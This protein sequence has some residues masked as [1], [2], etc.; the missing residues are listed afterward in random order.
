MALLVGRLAFRGLLLTA[1]IL[2]GQASKSTAAGESVGFGIVPH[3]D[4]TTHLDPGVAA[5][6]DATF[7]FFPSRASTAGRKVTPDMF[8]APEVCGGCHTEI[9]SQWK[10]SMH[11]NAWTDPVYRAALNAISKA[12]GG[13][14]DRF[15]M[16]C[17]TPVGVVTGEAT[18]SGDGM[19]AIAD[20]GVQCEV[21]HNISRSSGIGN[22][23]Y[24]LTPKLH[25]RPLKFG[26]FDDAA[27][28]YHDTAYSRLHTRSEFCGQCHDVTHPFNR[29]AIERTYS[30]WRDSV[31]AATGVQCQDCHMKPVR[32]RA[33]P[34]SKARERIYTHHF[35]G[36][37]TIVPKMLGSETHAKL[38][39]EMLRSAARVELFVAGRLTA[40]QAGTVRVR[41]T[42][43]GAGHKLPTGFPE[44]REM[45]IDFSV[46]DERGHV[47]YRSG[48]VKDGETEPGTQSFKVVLGDKD[49]KV[50]DLNV[51]DA[52]RILYDTR[53]EPKGS[54]DVDYVF[55][56]PA[57][58]SGR[59]Q[60]VADLNYWSFSQAFLDHLMGK[61]APRTRIIKMAGAAATVEIRRPR[62]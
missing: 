47:L 30:E 2:T 46:R 62:R 32:G 48:A 25:G 37:N 20:R 35:V 14:A 7:P 17:H 31:Y 10:G 57:T 12:S 40:G 58:L 49:G 53:L 6:D 42:N 33:T 3:P 8:D 28:P 22:G 19:S 1:I 56:L 34:F 11:S 38:A 4:N 29:T 36:G 60:L 61:D 23:A 26:P 24:V 18:P 27:S 9:Y 41:V 16:G 44:G 45:W 59:I 51:L 39:A 43:V 21:C 52:D 50:V 13:K 55:T 5:P 15:C 54:R